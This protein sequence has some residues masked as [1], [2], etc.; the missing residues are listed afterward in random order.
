MTDQALKGLNWLTW[1]L[2]VDDSRI[3]MEIVPEARA[4]I[5]GSAVQV[6]FRIRHETVERS[7]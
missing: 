7:L 2:A 6:E 1:N 3:L 4:G 5:A